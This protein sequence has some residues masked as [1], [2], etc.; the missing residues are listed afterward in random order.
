LTKTLATTQSAVRAGDLHQR[1]VAGMQVAHRGHERHAL[2]LSQALAQLV[3]RF[4]QFHPSSPSLRS[5]L[6]TGAA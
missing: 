1:E 6:R 4:H 2:R 3:G 5:R